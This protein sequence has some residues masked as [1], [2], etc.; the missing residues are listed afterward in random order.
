MF[1]K[2]ACVTIKHPF[3]PNELINS[4][5]TQLDC[6]ETISGDRK[7]PG[8]QLSLL[9]NYL[10]GNKYLIVLDDLSSITEW[11]TITHLFP[12]SVTK[13][14]IIVTTRQENVAKHCSKEDK[15]IYKLE[16]LGDRDAHS[17]FTEK[18]RY[19]II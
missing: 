17:L 9:A 1:D 13:S 5:A 12:T 2:R 16:I 15:N 18:V 19:H 3:D 7:K 6:K 11:D 14:R 4:L 8:N 10:E